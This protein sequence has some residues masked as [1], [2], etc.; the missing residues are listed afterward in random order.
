MNKTKKILVFVALIPLVILLKLYFFPASEVFKRTYKYAVKNEKGSIVECKIYESDKD[1]LIILLFQNNDRLHLL[2]KEKIIGLPDF[3][4]GNYKI[5]EDFLY[6]F[7]ENFFYNDGVRFRPFM[8]VLDDVDIN[9]NDTSV[10]I[11]GELP[12]P[13]LGIK[14]IIIGKKDSF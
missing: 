8:K 14:K 7:R 12:Y 4:L 10:E 1:G 5:K 13:R 3:G 9:F 11:I 6:L 2:F